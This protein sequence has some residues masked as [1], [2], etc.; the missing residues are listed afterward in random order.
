MSHSIVSPEVSLVVP[1]RN[2]F[3]SFSDECATPDVL[4]DSSDE[5]T[6]KQRSRGRSDHSSDDLEISAELMT[7][8][9]SSQ[10]FQL[11]T[12]GSKFEKQREKTHG[13]K[14]ASSEAYSVSITCDTSNCVHSQ[15]PYQ[16]ASQQLPIRLQ[17]SATQKSHL[18]NATPTTISADQHITM[19]S[20]R[21]QSTSPLHHPKEMG[22][23]EASQ[24]FYS[25]DYNSQAPSSQRQVVREKDTVTGDNRE[26]R[27]HYAPNHHCFKQFP[28]SFQR[29]AQEQPAKQQQQR[30]TFA[31]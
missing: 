4:S 22:K 6:V 20:L 12:L 8:L 25:I 23:A 19:S 24:K 10:E 7:H 16:K 5:E 28:P 1:V 27:F 18:A 21:L 13:G 29:M 2:R 26:T 17:Q 3:A 14:S 30:S 9:S 11:A 15:A 31:E